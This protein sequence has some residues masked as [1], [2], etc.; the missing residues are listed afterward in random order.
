MTTHEIRPKQLRALLLLLVLVP[1]IPIA[2]MARFMSD[3]LKGDRM[4]AIERTQQF[5]TDLLASALRSTPALE[6]K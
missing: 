3:A 5:Q 4:D 1:L 2:L 6:G